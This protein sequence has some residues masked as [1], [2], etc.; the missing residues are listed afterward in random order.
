MKND[1][2]ATKEKLIEILS[3]EKGY[4][5]RV[6]TWGQR[7]TEYEYIGYEL[8]E[9]FLPTLQKISDEQRK[10]LVMIMYYFEMH[11]HPLR[12]LLETKQKNQLDKLYSEIA[13]S[14]FM[15][16]VMFGM[17]EIAVKGERGVWLG[18]K[19][20]KIKKFLQ[21]NLSD[22]IK[23]DIAERYKVDKIFDYKKEVKSFSDVIDHMWSQ[24]RSGFIHDAG[25]ES[26]GLEWNTFEGIG[27][28]ENPIT[29]RSDV[30]I[31][32]WLQITWQAILNSYGYKGLLKLPKYKRNT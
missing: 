29:I 23:E 16:V 28:K 32:E 2:D 8:T 18:E 6:R 13:W 20:K 24:I 10:N 22:K 31:Q 9:D 17:L 1:L 5:G 27:T 12:D 4:F 7:P 26:K 19:G 15:T 25:I 3:Q 30:P 14:H 11:V 21:D